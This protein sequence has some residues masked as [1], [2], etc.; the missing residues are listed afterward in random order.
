M[1]LKRK[2]K[3]RYLQIYNLNIIYKRIQILH[4]AENTQRVMKEAEHTVVWG[5]PVL[6]RGRWS[7]DDSLHRLPMG[8]GGIL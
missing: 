8:G 6:D 5:G 7:P 1:A 4:R 3:I 2:K